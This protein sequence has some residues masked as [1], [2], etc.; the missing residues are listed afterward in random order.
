MSG[1]KPPQSTGL[2]MS[3][4]ALDPLHYILRLSTACVNLTNRSH[5]LSDPEALAAS[6]SATDGEVMR[7][8]EA[9]KL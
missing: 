5:I 8:I 1:G 4:E 9:R 6:G 2:A 3:H 7:L